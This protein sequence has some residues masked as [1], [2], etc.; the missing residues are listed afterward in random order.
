MGLGYNS[1]GKVGSAGASR[2]GYVTS[3]YN[4]LNVEG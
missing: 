2:G 3:E 4:K 1:A